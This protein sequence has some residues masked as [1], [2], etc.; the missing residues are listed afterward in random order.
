MLTSAT[1]FLF[2]KIDRSQFPACK[3]KWR[4]VFRQEKEAWIQAKYVNKKFVTKVKSTN[5]NLKSRLKRGNIVKRGSDGRLRAYTID[6][7][8]VLEG[9]PKNERRMDDSPKLD[10]SASPKELLH[11]TSSGD[12]FCTG[13]DSEDDHDVTSL[14][15]NMV[16]VYVY[17]ACAVEESY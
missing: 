2:C 7:I 1:Q 14:H 11:N 16:I 9:S 8:N 3:T 17:R 4:A 5:G 13:T 6:K 10:R 12:S 15:P